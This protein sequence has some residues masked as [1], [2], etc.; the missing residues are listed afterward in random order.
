MYAACSLLSECLEKVL[1]SPA[2]AVKV[3]H[4]KSH[5]QYTAQFCIRIIGAVETKKIHFRKDYRTVSIVSV[6]RVSWGANTYVMQ[7]IPVRKGD[8]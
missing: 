1:D 8:L 7:R 3:L 2:S 6:S 4:D 5:K